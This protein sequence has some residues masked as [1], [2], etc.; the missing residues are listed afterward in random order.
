MKLLAIKQLQKIFHYGIITSLE[1]ARDSGELVPL[2][3][4]ILG[5]EDSSELKSKAAKAVID[6][7]PQ[8]L[9]LTDLVIEN[10]LV[11]AL[12][13]LLHFPDGNVCEQWRN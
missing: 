6:S 3:N 1:D 2:L 13:K 4:E 12:L 9:E 7:I 11:E 10:K 5:I 8:L